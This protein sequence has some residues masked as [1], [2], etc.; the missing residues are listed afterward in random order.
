MNMPA[1]AANIQLLASGV[2][3]SNT[4]NTIPNRQRMDDN[5]L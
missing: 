5:K 4:P 3:P 1:A 2:E